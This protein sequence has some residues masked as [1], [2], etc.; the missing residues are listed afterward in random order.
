MT[1]SC[2]DLGNQ[3][4]HGNELRFASHQASDFLERCLFFGSKQMSILAVFIEAGVSAAK[5]VTSCVSGNEMKT[6]I[7][8]IPDAATRRRNTFQHR[9][10]NDATFDRGFNGLIE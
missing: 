9:K 2:V 3:I 7:E 4:T 1:P 6:L 8:F 10:S 5:F